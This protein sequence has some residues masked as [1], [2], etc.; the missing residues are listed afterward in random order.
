M[1]TQKSLREDWSEFE[2]KLP[3]VVVFSEQI[4]EWWLKKISFILSNIEKKIAER[5]SDVPSEFDTGSEFST[6]RIIRGN[7]YNE[8]LRDSLNI[9]SQFKDG[10][11]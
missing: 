11:K 7:G 2:A 10:L 5:K 3:E 8:G 4:G 1:E 9:I 6:P